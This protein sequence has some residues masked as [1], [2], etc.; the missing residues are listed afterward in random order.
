LT[1]RAVPVAN[2]LERSEHNPGR[3]EFLRE[4][5]VVED[6]KTCTPILGEQET[7][8]QSIGELEQILTKRLRIALAEVVMLV[9]AIGVPF[10]CTNVPPEYLEVSLVADG[11]LVLMLITRGY[12]F[13][14]HRQTR[15]ILAKQMKVSAK[16]RRRADTLYGLSILDPL[17]TLHNRRFGEQRLKEEIGRSERCGDPLAVLLFDLDYF[18][19]I[20][21]KFGHL[22]GDLALKEFSRSLKR[23]I[24]ACDVPVRMGG[25]EFLVVLPDCPRDKVDAILSRIGTPEIEFNRQRISIRCSTGRAQYQYSDTPET[26][27]GRADEVLYASKAARPTSSHLPKSAGNQLQTEELEDPSCTIDIACNSMSYSATSVIRD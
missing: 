21:D 12:E 1:G 7:F 3:T 13:I 8:R 22:A 6:I 17:T 14:Q 16:Q 2:D 25:D 20:N 23:A 24:R 10:L 18:K 9:A 15:L 11:F 4:R 5:G 27:L 26:L 19:E